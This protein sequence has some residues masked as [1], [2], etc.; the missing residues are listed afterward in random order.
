MQIDFQVGDGVKFYIDDD[1]SVTYGKIS[2]VKGA[3]CDVV[4]EFHGQFHEIRV[5]KNELNFD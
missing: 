1:I 2:M 3:Y 4:F 5:K